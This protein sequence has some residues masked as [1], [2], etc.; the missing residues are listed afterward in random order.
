MQQKNVKMGWW[1][2]WKGWADLNNVMQ[3]G[4]WIYLREINF[5]DNLVHRLPHPRHVYA[6]FLLMIMLTYKTGDVIFNSHT[7]KAHNASRNK[8]IHWNFDITDRQGTG[9][10]GTLCR[11]YVIS[12]G[13]CT[14]SVPYGPKNWYVMSKCTLLGCSSYRSLSVQTTTTTVNLK[15]I[16]RKCWI[17]TS[18]QSMGQ[19]RRDRSSVPCAHPVSFQ[20]STSNS[21]SQIT[22]QKNNFNAITVNMWLFE[23]VPL[24]LP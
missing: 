3:T 11:M 12:N 6:A 14:K 7:S 23:A 18:G 4:L 20:N 15:L 21:I 1:W 9:K 8:R 19:R 17:A 5:T 16:G 24:P 22:P 13:F 10:F 2:W